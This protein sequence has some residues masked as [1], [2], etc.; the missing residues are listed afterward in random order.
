MGLYKIIVLI[1]SGLTHNFMSTRLANMLQLSI[2]P[3]ITFSVRVV[4]GEKLTC[5]GN[6]EKVQVLIQDVP[7]SLI[8]Y[9][10]PIIGLDMVLGIQWL[11]MLASVVCN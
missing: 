6:F 9:S 11:E 10:L 7:F 8:V 2:I 3:T 4:K 5:Q 1:D